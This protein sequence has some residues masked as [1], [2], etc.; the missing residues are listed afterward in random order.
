MQG[1]VYASQVCYYCTYPLY[2]GHVLVNGPCPHGRT[3]LWGPLLSTIW[4]SVGHME[5]LFSSMCT[6]ILSLG[7]RATDDTLFGLAL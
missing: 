6:V 5:A 7:K 3:V 1:I 2:L 4:S